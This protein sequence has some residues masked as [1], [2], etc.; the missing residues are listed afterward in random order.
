MKYPTFEEL[1]EYAKLYCQGA[2][3]VAKKL[4]IQAE[5]E[6]ET[7]SHP[8]SRLSQPTPPS[9]AKSKKAAVKHSPD[10][11][12]VV[13]FGEPYTFTPTQAAIV[14][15]LWEAWEDD[16][17]GVGQVALLEAVGSDSN[18]LRDVFKDHPAWGTMIVSGAKGM[19]RLEGE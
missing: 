7:I 14:E 13:W 12:S 17:P 2:G 8:I 18:R 19:Y 15:K 16:C 5:K 6:D 1:L 9:A 4:T 3:I 11:R 10:F